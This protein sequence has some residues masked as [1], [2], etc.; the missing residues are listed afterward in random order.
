MCSALCAPLAARDG[1]APSRVWLAEGGWQTIGQFLVVRFPHVTEADLRW[2]CAQGDIVNT[3]GEPMAFDTPYA[4]QAKQ[5]L[6]YYRV[7]PNEVPVPFEMPILYADETL[8]AVDK[9]HFL[10]STPGGQ[11][12]QHT[13]LTRLRRH[14]NEMAISPLHRLDR[15]TAGVLLFCRQPAL[16]GAYQSLFQQQAV[17]R[18]YEAIAPA[19][20]T[21]L[22]QRLPLRH[23]SRLVQPKNQ[24]FVE[25][26]AGEANSHTEITPLQPLSAALCLYSLRPLTGRKHQLRVHLSA[27]GS[28]ILHDSYYPARPAMPQPDDY[29]KPLQLLARRLAFVDP[30]SGQSR[31]FVSQRKLIVL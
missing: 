13:A 17:Q 5:W 16:R 18:E 22:M 14:F 11:Y 7:V 25:E 30:L 23:S 27:L 26:V 19:L 29:S 2:R 31:E 28:P 6:W 21:E 1:V 9:P 10:A 15:E 8:I 12:L 20:P 4:P 24:L 3:A